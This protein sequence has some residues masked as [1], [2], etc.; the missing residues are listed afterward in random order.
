MPRPAPP[1]RRG[2]APRR[3]PRA[4]WCGRSRP[5]PRS[6]AGAGPP[7]RGRRRRDRRPDRRR[8]AAPRCRRR[9]RAGR[10]LATARRRAGSGS[11]RARR[12]RWATAG[13]RASATASR[14]PDRDPDDLDLSAGRRVD[15]AARHER[16]TRG[17]GQEV[18][19]ADV[20]LRERQ[21]DATAEERRQLARE[22]VLAAEG[23]DVD[24][25]RRPRGDH[26]AQAAPAATSPRRSGRCGSRTA[27]S[28]R[29][30]RRSTAARP[31]RWI[32]RTCDAAPH[33]RAR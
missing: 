3:G 20:L 13:R 19:T 28:R 10:R 24:A 11:S 22:Q 33:P 2:A 25:E 5:V 12:R 16:R 26:G 4:R 7:R 1:H 6:A 23:H 30:R 27:P 18:R 9:R 31:P 8:R 32:R 17:P 21:Q 14:P 15:A 29:S